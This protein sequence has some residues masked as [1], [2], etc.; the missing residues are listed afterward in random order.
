[1]S[2]ESEIAVITPPFEV[3][4]DCAL[5]YSG[6]NML[7]MLPK[8]S[9]PD[10]C[11]IE[12]EQVKEYH[13]HTPNGVNAHSC[14]LAVES[15]SA[16]DIYSRMKICTSRKSVFRYCRDFRCGRKPHALG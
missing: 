7:G 4:D 1:M 10:S 16:S 9:D 15:V 5:S 8:S 11:V 2:S 3:K 13:S 12:W 14:N 6:R